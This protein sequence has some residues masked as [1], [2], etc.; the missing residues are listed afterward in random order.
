MKLLTAEHAVAGGVIDGQRWRTADYRTL[1]GWEVELRDGRILLTLENGLVALLVPASV[2]MDLTRSLKR[3][4]IHGPVFAVD[5]PRPHWLFL[6]DS[7]E[8]VIATDDLPGGVEVLGFGERI[9]LP[10]VEAFSAGVRWI[11][12]PDPRQRWL[13][14][15]AAVLLGMRRTIRAV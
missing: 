12:A 6:A 1:F 4:D 10:C 14:T 7:N 9:P 3:L 5:G 15:L 2:A 11:V 8:Y 13:P